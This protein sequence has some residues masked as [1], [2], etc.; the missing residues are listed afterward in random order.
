MK[1]IAIL[2]FLMLGLAAGAQQPEPDCS[3][4]IYLKN[5]SVFKGSIVAYTP[6]AEMQFKTWNGI[7]LRLDDQNIR[8]VVQRCKEDGTHAPR[9]YSFKETGWY[10]NTRLGLLGG[11]DYYEYPRTGFLIQ[12]SSGYQWNRWLGAG[13][14]IGAEV[15][16]PGDDAGTYPLFAEV[17]GYLRANKIS[18][19]YAAGAG[20]GFSNKYSNVQNWGENSRYKGGF[21]AQLQLGYRFGNHVTVHTGIRLQ[22]KKRE[23]SSIWSSD[24]GT[25]RI[26]H[27][28]FELGF[29]LL[30]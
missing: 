1:N 4:W 3:D 7:D 30:F 18:P 21:M 2:F 19:F 6:G 20:W 16:N 24:Q 13:I 5:G 15:F 8:K 12:H 27:R 10:H 14:G 28:R 25:D 9:P 29:G 26:L 11:V 22:Q 17:R 23:W